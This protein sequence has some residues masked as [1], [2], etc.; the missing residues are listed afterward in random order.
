M[1]KL[2]RSDLPADNPW[3]KKVRKLR[4]ENPRYTR[5]PQ[6][7]EVT[8]DDP[9]SPEEKTALAR[10]KKRVKQ[11]PKLKTQAE[12]LIELAL[13]AKAKTGAKSIKKAVQSLELAISKSKLSDPKVIQQVML[14][15]QLVSPFIE[16]I[17]EAVSYSYDQ[18]NMAASCV[19]KSEDGKLYSC[20]SPLLRD[21][22]IYSDR[23]G[24]LD[25]YGGNEGEA[26]PMS[27]SEMINAVANGEEPR[28]LIERV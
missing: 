26:I 23:H 5:P 2:Y 24:W 27:P 19:G 17:D 16:G 7:M 25:Y 8:L 4:K 18:R 22:Q 28:Q 15:K 3:S 12:S 1:S 20:G 13:A 14:L 10:N 6:P 11:N 21:G 9:L